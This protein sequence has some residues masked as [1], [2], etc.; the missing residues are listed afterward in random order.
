MRNRIGSATP[1]ELAVVYAI[2]AVIVLTNGSARAGDDCLAAPSSDPPHGSHWYY[3]LESVPQ[4]HC[5]FLGAEGRKVR[6]EPEVQSMAK[7]TA[8]IRTE[9]TGD[10]LTAFAQ[11]EP[12]LPPRRPAIAPSALA[13][14]SVEGIA[15]EAPQGNSAIVPRPDSGRAADGSDRKSGAA[16]T[17]QDINANEELARSAA[18]EV[19]NARVIMLIRVALL[20]ASALAVAGIVQY[21]AFRIAVKPRPPVYVERGRAERTV[22]IARERMPPAFATTRRNG[23][24][25]PPDEQIDPQDI[26]AG[27]RRILEAMRRQ[28]A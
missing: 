12:P 3:R 5:W 27:I 25:R 24:K 17:L 4:R 26:E 9:T 23:P 14:A 13:Q 16:S 1:K 18:A 28:A 6:V 8:S 7:S 2:T 22:S 10:R 19:A 21:A 15:Q 11:A 20:V